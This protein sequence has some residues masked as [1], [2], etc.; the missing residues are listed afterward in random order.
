MKNLLFKDLRIGV[1]PL[2]Y[3]LTIIFG[4]LMFIPGWVY[5]IVPLYYA[6]VTVPNVMA[7]FRSSND[8]TM[9]V[10]MPVRKKD[11]IKARMITFGILQLMH[12][13]FAVVFALFN[14]HLYKDWPFLFMRP[15][16]AFFGIAFIIYGVFNLIVFPIHYKTAYKYGFA[17]ILGNS[18][19]LAL[20]TAV[21]LTYI[22]WA[23]FREY[24]SGPT[25]AVHLG[26]LGAGILIFG[27]TAFIAYNISV[28]NF[29][30][31]DI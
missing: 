30:K 11:I 29:E 4:A 16:V 19:V 10:L 5:F 12:I 22:K 2:F 31:V 21:E 28:K 3:V 1:S 18:I 26:I 20:A 9:S 7:G 17:V 14:N 8:L 25:D 27:I 13:G 23:S 15:N 24:L 6:F